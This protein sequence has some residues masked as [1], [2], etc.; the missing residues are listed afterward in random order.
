M[1]LAQGHHDQDGKVPPCSLPHQ[2]VS[3]QEPADLRRRKRALRGGRARP[4]A[5][6]MLE[7]IVPKL[8]GA[9]IAS[10]ITEAGGQDWRTTLWPPSVR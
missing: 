2:K 5:T 8:S 9:S 7:S 3:I 10:I 6:R 4:Q 1:L